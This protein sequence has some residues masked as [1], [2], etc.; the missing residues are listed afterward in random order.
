MCGKSENV[1]P[2]RALIRMCESV[3]RRT[4][5]SDDRTG[6]VANR[7]HTNGEGGEPKLI[8]AVRLERRHT[9]TAQ[10]SVRKC[11]RQFRQSCTH[12]SCAMTFSRAPTR[13]QTHC[14]CAASMW[15]PETCASRF[16]CAGVCI[17]CEYA[18]RNLHAFAFRCENT[19]DLFLWAT[20]QQFGGGARKCSRSAN[21]NVLLGIH[22]GVVPLVRVIVRAQ[23]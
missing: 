19:D 16:R 13:V 21:P 6:A 14:G 10:T 20:H 5:M 9:D 15:L 4:A 7:E 12:T 11:C 8:V 22:G 1:L 23:R 17:A 3:A 2:V 18:R